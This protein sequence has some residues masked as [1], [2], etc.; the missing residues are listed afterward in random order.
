MHK[1]SGMRGIHIR[2]GAAGVAVALSVFC[3]TS[4]SCYAVEGKVTAETAKIR[5]QT[6]TDSEVVGSTQRGKTIDI[7]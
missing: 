7:L 6:S 1:I 3:L 4:L 2:K 5:A